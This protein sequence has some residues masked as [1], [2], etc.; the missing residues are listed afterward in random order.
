[1]MVVL[2]SI[3]YLKIFQT[4]LIFQQDDTN[5]REKSGEA[6]L[7]RITHPLAQAI[8]DRAKKRD[9][10]PVRLIFDYQ[11]HNGR[12][13]TLEPYRGRSGQ[14][15]AKLISISA[16][17]DTEQHILIAAITETVKSYKLTIQKNFCAC[18]HKLPK[19]Q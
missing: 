12:I 14:L 10:P 1:M 18:L 4:T 13:S 9:C 7:Y 6:Y 16:L 8:I 15:I 17:G 2:Y 5:C 3:S 19:P 11:E